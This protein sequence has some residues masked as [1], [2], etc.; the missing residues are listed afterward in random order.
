ML[1]LKVCGVKDPDNFQAVQ[2]LKPDFIGLNFYN[3]SPRYAG[4]RNVFK[5]SEGT[6]LVGIFVNEPLE[7]ILGLSNNFNLDLIQLHGKETFDDCALLNKKGKKIIKAFSVD[8]NFDFNEVE[9][10]MPYCDYF[11]FD[12]AGVQPGGTGRK[13]NWDILKYYP[14]RKPFF[15]AGGIS[16]E[17]AHDIFNYKV[18]QLYALDVNS[19]FE[20]SPGIKDIDKL[21]ELQHLIKS[22]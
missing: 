10:Y 22:K 11:L 7:N 15:L 3:K 8:D 21:K 13:F 20:Q 18:P 2:E 5:K 4:T 9:P 12:T 16:P 17:N 14:F 19:G 1:K 6:A